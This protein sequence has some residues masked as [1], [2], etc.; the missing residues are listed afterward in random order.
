LYICYPFGKHEIYSLEETSTCEY[1]IVVLS[2][3]LCQHPDFR[4]R[5]TDENIINCYS[6]AA[7]KM[8]KALVELETE[9]FKIRHE[10]L[11]QNLESLLET[12]IKG[13]V[14][15]VELYSE[16]EEESLLRPVKPPV[17]DTSFVTNFLSGKN[18]LTGGS[19][20]WKF[21]FCYGK[22][23]LQFHEEPNSPSRTEI[24][25]GK[26]DLEKHKEFLDKNPHKKSISLASKKQISHFY[27]GGASCDQTGQPRVVE[28]KFKCVDAPSPSAIAL[29]LL[30]PKT[31][32]Y[33]LGVE[34]SVL[35]PVLQSSDDY[36]LFDTSKILA[37]TEE[38]LK[39]RKLATA[40]AEDLFGRV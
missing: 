30:E 3:N 1:E 23:V 10:H 6:M 29:Y 15:P 39:S 22:H 5:E 36:G 18:C 35:C 21:E 31:C 34:S 8:P 9:S 2:Q 37:G 40:D 38:K 28:V 14:R 32:E 19:H 27:T 17:Q 13:D 4:S 26:W 12:K 16:E 33:A 25:L 20:W 11:L 24:Y 7:P